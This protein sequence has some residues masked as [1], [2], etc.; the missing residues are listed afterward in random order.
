MSLNV[1]DLRHALAG[2]HGSIR[3]AVPLAPMTHVRIGGSAAVFIEPKTESDVS[4]VVRAAR[5]FDQPIH[6]LG[7]GSNIVVA[8]AGLA[9]LTVSLAHLNRVMRDGGRVTAGAGVTLPSL[10]RGTK[11]LGLSGLEVLIGIPAVVGGAVA[12]NAGTHDGATFDRLVSLTLV[13]ADGEIR[14]LGAGEMQPSYRDGGL[15]DQLV[16]QATFELE[17]DDTTTIFERMEASLKRRN[18]TQPVTEKCVGC[19]FRNP[20]GESA[21]RLIEESGCKTMR[22]G[23]VVVS[24][25]HA[26]YFVNEG[27]G[28]S[29]DFLDLM[30]EVHDRVATE[31]SIEL[32]PE[33]KIWGA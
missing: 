33:V 16:V 11:D 14:V 10:I 22:R 20:P 7:G 9:G 12:M 4:R 27:G 8:D 23:K 3:E 15:G 26:N 17:E 30:A 31:F 5:E 24:G 1:S 28:T 2:F 19:V 21:G 18:A 13:D 25:K 29:K 32:L 6:L